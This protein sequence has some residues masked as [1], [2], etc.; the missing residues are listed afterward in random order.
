M[1][2]LLQKK[3]QKK[4]HSKGA[5]QGIFILKKA[6]TKS[7]QVNKKEKYEAPGPEMQWTFKLQEIRVL[8]AHLRNAYMETMMFTCES[9]IY[10]LFSK[11]FF[12]LY[13]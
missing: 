11:C 7:Q 10:F 1:I 3:Q 4:C 2:H 12:L 8:N 5:I 6:V 13:S 9:P